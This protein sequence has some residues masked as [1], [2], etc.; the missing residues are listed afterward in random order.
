MFKVYESP[1]GPTLKLV[2]VNV[3]STSSGVDESVTVT[4]KLAEPVFPAASVAVHVTVV[5]PSGYV[6]GMP[7]LF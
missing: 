6:G 4:V 5:V 1:A 3:F 7:I 2:I